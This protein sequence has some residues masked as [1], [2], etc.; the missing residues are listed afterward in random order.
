[1]CY[2]LLNSNKSID[3]KILFYLSNLSLD[4][5]NNVRITLAELISSILKGDSVWKHNFEINKIAHILKNDKVKTVRD[6]FIEDVINEK[7]DSLHTGYS[8]NLF[9]CDME[10]VYKEFG[11][12]NH[13]KYISR[14]C[15]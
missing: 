10:F 14:E 12:G 2:K 5:I 15:K 1:M 8:N 11:I 9:I 3:D 13:S 6:Y 4:K 7:N